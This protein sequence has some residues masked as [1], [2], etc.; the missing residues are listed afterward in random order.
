MNI[1]IQD[2]DSSWNRKSVWGELSES[3][4]RGMITWLGSMIFEDDVC[5]DFGGND[6]RCAEAFRRSTH[7][8]MVVCDGLET[9][10]EVAREHGL[11]TVHCELEKLDFAD[12]SVNWGFCSHTLEHVVGFG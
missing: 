4:V 3:R 8:P 5:V 6:G 2:K 11:K 9:R 7:I 12:D 1:E 10:L